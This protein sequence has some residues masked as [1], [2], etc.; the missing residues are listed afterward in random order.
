[1]IILDIKMPEMNGF[2]YIYRQRKKIVHRV[3]ICSLTASEM[4]YVAYGDMFN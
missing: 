3:K 2:E 1:M 4:Y